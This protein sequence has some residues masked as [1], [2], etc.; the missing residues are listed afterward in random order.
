M[1]LQLQ[2]R[3]ARTGDRLV[4]NLYG[5]TYYDD[6]GAETYRIMRE[7]WARGSGSDTQ[8]SMAQP[9]M[10]DSKHRLLWQAGVAGATLREQDL[11]GSHFCTLMREAAVTVAWLHRSPVSC[12]RLFSLDDWLV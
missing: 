5:K 11:G 6:N 2:V 7:L 9:M 3:Q 8:S 10:Y 12:S 1:R 4:L